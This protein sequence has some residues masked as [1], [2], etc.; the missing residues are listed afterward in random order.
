ML[1]VFGDRIALQ[2]KVVTEGTAVLHTSCVWHLLALILGAHIVYYK[3]I[4]SEY[5][6]QTGAL[7]STIQESSWFKPAG[8]S[9]SVWGL[10]VPGTPSSS[11]IPKTRMLD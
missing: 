4:L 9:L 5:G 7:V 11:H 6:Q 1:Q 8:S 3:Q 10:H 2:S